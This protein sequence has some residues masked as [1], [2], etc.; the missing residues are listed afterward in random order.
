M[1]IVT[2]IFKTP[3]KD[4]WKIDLETPKMFKIACNGW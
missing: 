1:S 4:Y 2:S 3:F